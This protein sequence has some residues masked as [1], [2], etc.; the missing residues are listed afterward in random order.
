MKQQEG[1]GTQLVVTPHQALQFGG[2]E[3]ER[4]AVDMRLP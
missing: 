2:E 1:K 3:F 4:V